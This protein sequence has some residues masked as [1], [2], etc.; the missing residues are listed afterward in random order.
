[1]RFEVRVLTTAGEI[2]RLAHVSGTVGLQ[3]LRDLVLAYKIEPESVAWAECW[4]VD[5]VV[6]PIPAIYA[7]LETWQPATVEVV[8]AARKSAGI[9]GAFL[10]AV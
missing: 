3:R 6:K 7:P 5:P 10:P 1:M 4:L 2:I 9:D 8:A